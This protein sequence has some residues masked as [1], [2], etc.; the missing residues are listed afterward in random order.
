MN[1]HV[2]YSGRCE[3]HFKSA[4]MKDD[5]K[6]SFFDDERCDMVYEN[7]R[8]SPIKCVT[9]VLPPGACCPI[10]GEYCEE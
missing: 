2:D 3:Y 5:E 4:V 1:V 6:G 10:C 7:G 9:N 8:C